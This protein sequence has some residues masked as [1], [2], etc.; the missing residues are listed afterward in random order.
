MKAFF[1]EFLSRDRFCL[2]LSAL[3]IPLFFTIK[4]E[5]V[6]IKSIRLGSFLRSVYY[7]SLEIV[8]CN[9][10]E[11]NPGKSFFLFKNYAYIFLFSVLCS[12]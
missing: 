12:S 5:C 4:I 8:L 3:F 10:F 6:F 1:L 7:L 2:I 11:W 9:T